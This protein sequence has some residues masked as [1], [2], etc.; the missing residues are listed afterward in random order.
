MKK[1]NKKLIR[2]I[3]LNKSQFIT[4]FLMVFIGILAYS[5]IESYMKGMQ[6][7][8][9]IF[10]SDNNLQD[11]NVMGANFTEDDL[12]NIKDID[13]VKDAE[14]KLVVTANQVTDGDKTLLLSF[15]ETNNI[16]KLYIY[17]GENFDGSKQGIWID[18]FYAIENNLKVGDTIEIKYDGYIF[19]E[20]INGLINVPDHLYD[21]KDES[22]LIPNRSS[23]GFAYLSSN[24]LE[25][26]IKSKTME[27]FNLT[28]EETFDNIVP[29]FDFKENLI[30]NYIMVDVDSKENV[31][32]VKDK[33]EEK[34][35]NAKAIIKIED[36]DSYK[37]YQG[38]IDEGKTYV[39]VFSGLFIFIAMLSVITTM[40]RVVKKQRS[41]IGALKALGFKDRQI[42]LHYMGYGF[43]ISLVASILG[44]IAGL[45]TIGNMF[46]SLQMSFF[47]IPNGK[48]MMDDKTYIVAILVVLCTCLVTY[49]TCRKQ[50]KEKPAETLK[51]EIPKVKG[52]SLD[53]TT[54]GIFKKMS[55]ANKW[56]IRDMF[57]NKF[58]TVTGIV[59]ITGCCMLIVCAFGMLDSMNHFIELQFENLL[60]FDYKLSIKENITDEE[61]EK[62]KE[63]YGNVTSQ[64][65]LIEI[66]DQNG[67]KESNNIFV[68]D[69]DDY[70]RF[71]DNKENFIKL[72]NSKGVYI[73]YKLAKTRGYNIG[74]TI[75]WH[76]VGNDKYYKSEIVGFNKDP[77]NQNMTM[78]REYFESI[79]NTYR[80]DSLYTNKDLSQNKEIEN[81]ELIQNKNELKNG[82][83]TMLSMMKSMIIL[84]IAVAIILG[85]VII[86]NLGI[87][88]YT[89]KGYQ[90]ATLKV[91]GFSDK[92]IRKIFIKQNN[93]ISIISIIFGLPLGFYLTDWLFKTAIEEGYDFAA[94]IGIATYIIAAIG[95]FSISLIV[96][97][98]LSKKINKIDMVSSLKGNE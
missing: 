3:K 72:D 13:N 80:A 1:L 34:V 68:T 14:R 20:K 12:K 23:F 42:I 71:I 87:L 35:E 91:L 40:T 24:E 56:N 61:L 50:L 55:F 93:I 32:S 27:K 98:I 74:D 97:K 11:L 15:I 95:T 22:E 86:Y 38:E 41:Q 29:N 83:S 89:E 46:M 18:N 10:Y 47:E 96:S 82:M 9:E 65:Y 21:V 59:G 53:I 44:L 76:L 79:G 45:Y 88:S 94:S 54:K 49:L 48:P 84:I 92:K 36:T 25:G 8:A 90:F 28:N 81:V 2:D 6:D 66:K 52:K 78:T 7:T 77:Q 37:Q 63:Q 33:I 62:L 70:V 39:G 69:C 58:R 73:T 75:E 43:W 4:I 57:R 16:S 19:K 64:S 30:F 67:N 31:S 51:N 26:Y 17:D 85:V 5:G 60:N